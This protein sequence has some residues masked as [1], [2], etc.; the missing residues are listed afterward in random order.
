MTEFLDDLPAHAADPYLIGAP[1]GVAAVLLVESLIHGLLARRLIDLGDAIDI[2]DTA[3]DVAM[4]I[5]TQPGR[6]P[7][8]EDPAVTILTRIADSLRI[9]LPG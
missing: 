2:V 7:I 9:D 6:P 4:E 8:A 5:A 1:S 3:I